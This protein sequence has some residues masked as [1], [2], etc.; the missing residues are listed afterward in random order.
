MPAGTFLR[1]YWLQFLDLLLFW[2]LSLP[3]LVL[4][5]SVAGESLVHL[6]LAC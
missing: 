6:G 2:G 1:G 4:A 3:L 5:A